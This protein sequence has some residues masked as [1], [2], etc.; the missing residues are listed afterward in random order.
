MGNKEDRSE[1]SFAE[2]PGKNFNTFDAISMLRA[3]YMVAMYL[4]QNV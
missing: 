3:A 4:R 2:N 1:K